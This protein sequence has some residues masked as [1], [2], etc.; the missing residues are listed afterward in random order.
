MV[1][2]TN[3]QCIQIDFISRNDLALHLFLTLYVL[4][5]TD[6]EEALLHVFVLAGELE[7]FL[8][9]F[10]LNCYNSLYGLTCTLVCWSDS[11]VLNVN[12]GL[13]SIV[14]SKKQSIYEKWVKLLRFSI[15]WY[16]R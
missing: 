15:I 1:D 8:E 4:V 9:V 10:P 11:V 12:S 2:R 3:R 14:T 7:G 6:F 16:S 5:Q 13:S